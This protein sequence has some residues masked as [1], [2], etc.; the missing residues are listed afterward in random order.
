MKNIIYKDGELIHEATVEDFSVVRLKASHKYTELPHFLCWLMR[1]GFYQVYAI[2]E[3]LPQP[4]AK[5]T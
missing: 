5:K 1:A 3:F 2:A 4:V